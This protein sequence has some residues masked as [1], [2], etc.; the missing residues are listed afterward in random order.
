MPIATASKTK[1]ALTIGFPVALLISVVSILILKGYAPWDYPQ[2]I[3]TGALSWPIHLLGWVGAL[4]WI[5]VYWPKS[6]DAWKRPTLVE[7]C[8]DHFVFR[9][10]SAPIE[11]RKIRNVVFKP[12]AA[13]RKLTIHLV[14]GE[15]ID[16]AAFLFSQDGHEV[17]K[18]LKTLSAEASLR[19]S[20]VS[21][22]GGSETR[23]A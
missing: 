12:Y 21:D 16:Q 10:W 14:T 11:K 3:A 20:P 6:I 23:C 5:G 2:L 7:E 18:R 22:A 1:I 8:G 9:D 15:R 19:S 4:A 17:A 13:V